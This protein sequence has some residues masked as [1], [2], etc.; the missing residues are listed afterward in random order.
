ME[1]ASRKNI[2][3]ISAA[4]AAIVS[5]PLLVV[6]V[7]IPAAADSWP[8]NENFRPDRGSHTYCWSNSS[9][10]T[11]AVRN[12]MYYAM[13]YMN[14]NTKAKRAYHLH[15]DLSGSGQTD[16]VWARGGSAIGTARCVVKWSNRR[17]DRYDVRVNETLI[18]D[19]Y[20]NSTHRT[21]Q[22][23]KTACHELGHTLGLNHFTTNHDRYGNGDTS[24][25]HGSCQRS[26]WDGKVTSSWIRTWESH[27]R[28]HI[29]NWFD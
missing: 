22:Y 7:A 21:R 17:C 27:H 23:R 4:L 25:Y 12:Q 20:S 5:I 3:L 15:C 9:L 16:V 19:H 11:E 1:S 6:A 29:N 26:G 2:R 13:D 28:S 18:R 24:Y 8:V 10:P 14:D